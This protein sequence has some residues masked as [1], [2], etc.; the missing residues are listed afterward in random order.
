MKLLLILLL[1]F[2]SAL[3][4]FAQSPEEIMREAYPDEPVVTELTQFD[5][6]WKNM[7]QARKEGDERTY[8][9]ISEQLKSEF[10]ERFVGSQIPVPVSFASQDEINRLHSGLMTEAELQVFS[11]NLATFGTV[12]QSGGNPRTV[13]LRSA[14]DGTQYLAFGPATNDTLYIFRSTDGGTSWGIFTLLTMTGNTG[15]GMDLYITDTTSSYR[16]GVILSTETTTE[17][18][19]LTFVS[20]SP[21]SPLPVFASTFALPDPDRGLINPVIVSDGYYYA[22]AS[23]YWYVAYQD[24]S[25]TTPTNNPIRAALTTD[26]GQTWVFTTARSGFNDYD[27]AIEFNTSTIEDS[28]YVLLSNNLTIANPNLRLRRV[29]LSN[30]TGTFSQFNPATTTEPEFHGMLKVDRE[31]GEMICTFTRTQGGINNAAYVF[32]RPG[33]PFFNAANPIFIAAN[34]WNEGGIDVDWVSGV[35]VWRLAYLS[36]GAADTVV[37]KWSFNLENG[38]DGHWVVNETNA[39][40]QIFPSVGGLV[41]GVLLE[42][43]DYSTGVAYAGSGNSG[44]YYNNISDTQIPVELTSFTANVIGQSVHLHWKT[45]SEINNMGFE[46]ERKNESEFISLGFINGNGTTT[47]IS[48]YSFVDKSLTAGTYSYRLKQIDFDGTFEYSNIIEITVLTPGNFMLSQNYPNPFN[49]STIISYSIP[50]VSSVK[51][52]LFSVTGENLATLVNSEQEAGIY[53]Y[54]LNSDVLQLA[55]GAY[56][57]RMTAIDNNSGK[58]FIETKK[59]LLMK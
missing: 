27:V 4:S 22:P 39:S 23:T 16:I 28:V 19:V 32:S 14:P 37:F 57:Y 18:G 53:N 26:W 11:G 47:G 55:T 40:N 5:I 30:F 13:R 15:K 1:S 56:F 51:I 3:L 17:N 54:E 20:F 8:H 52:E 9:Q 35:S 6:L 2:V 42:G 31:T 36:S 41:S 50:S 12:T 29:A 46:V 45:A 33:G 38:F 49:P 44:L 21:G 48:E 43:V 25:A 10:P 34:G 59:L 7:I 58:Q 24:Y